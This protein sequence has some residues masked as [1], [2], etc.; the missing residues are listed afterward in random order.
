MLFPQKEKGSETEV[1]GQWP[2]GSSER[3]GK[4]LSV[5]S[6][7]RIALR[8]TAGTNPSPPASSLQQIK[9]SP[10]QKPMPCVGVCAEQALMWAVTSALTPLWE[11]VLGQLKAPHPSLQ[12]PPGGTASWRNSPMMIS[13]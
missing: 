11:C 6:C 12:G 4:V 3:E 7:T 8:S 10:I 13:L 9:A 2:E 1:T 5:S